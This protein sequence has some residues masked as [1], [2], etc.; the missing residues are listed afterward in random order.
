M[1]RVNELVF[2]RK[3]AR[4]EYRQAANLSDCRGDVLPS[5]MSSRPSMVSVSHI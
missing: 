3:V 1:A 5:S 4:A 2:M